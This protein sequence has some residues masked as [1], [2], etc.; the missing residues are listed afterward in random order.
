MTGCPENK[1][2][3]SLQ[4]MDLTNIQIVVLTETKITS[5][6]YPNAFGYKIKD[7][8]AAFHYIGGVALAWQPNHPLFTIESETLHGPNVIRAELVSGGMWRLIIR[9][10]VAPS[11]TSLE[12]MQHV[13]ARQRCPD[14]PVIILGDF[15][16]DLRR[17]PIQATGNTRATTLYAAIANLGVDDISSQVRQKY[18]RLD[19][20]Q[21]G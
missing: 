1:L 15:N 3:Q 8:T 20:P 18:L 11:K 4:A 16:V 21:T 2:V 7:S 10:Y 6:A 9:A 13:A 5:E 12:T 17:I 19:L 14:L